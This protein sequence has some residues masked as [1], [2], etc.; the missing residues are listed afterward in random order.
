MD[1]QQWMFMSAHNTPILSSCNENVF[2]YPSELAKRVFYINALL[3][4]LVIIAPPVLSFFKSCSIK[5]F[6]SLSPRDVA[7]ILKV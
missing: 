1:N 7:M 4:M 3:L 6:N 5:F 2:I